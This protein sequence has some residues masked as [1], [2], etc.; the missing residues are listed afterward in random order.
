M[1]S[2]L[3]FL[4]GVDFMNQNGS[5][6]DVD[7]NRVSEINDLERQIRHLDQEISSLAYRR[8]FLKHRLSDLKYEIQTSG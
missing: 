4:L 1:I 3:S 7:Q 5:L 2:R 6:D 8:K